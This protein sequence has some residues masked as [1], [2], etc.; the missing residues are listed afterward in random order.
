[1][2]ATNKKHK[3]DKHTLYHA[4]ALALLGA[5]SAYAADDAKP[6]DEN[7]ERVEVTGTRLKGVDMEG[8]SPVIDID[9]E[10][11]EKRGYD[12]VG[13]FL[14]DL[15]QTS[16]AGTFSEAGGIASGTRGQPA[17]SAGVS[18]R[19]LGSS[20]T[21]VLINGRRVAVDSFTNGFDSFVDVN[22]IPMSAIDRIEVLTDG[23]SSIYGSD[24]IAGVINFIL[25]K[26]YTGQE[27]SVMYGDDTAKD[28]FGRYN[29]TY[30]GGFAT[31][32][33]NTTVVLDYY[34]RNA[35]MNS[36]R[37]IDVTLYSSTRVTIDGVDHPEPWCG[38]D[39]SNG[40]TRCRYDY[41]S[42]RAI[43]S[44]T[45]NLGFTL[46]H[47]YDLGEGSEFF[48]EVMYQRNEGHAYEAPSS[49]S[50]WVPAGSA[51]IPQWALDI[52]ALDG[53]ADDIR[54]RSRFPDLRTQEFEDTTYRALAG[55]RGTIGNWDWESGLAIGKAESTIRHVAGFYNID[56][57]DAAADNGTFNP[58]NL[59]RDNSEATLAS[60]RETAPRTGESE[61]KTWD[62]RFNGD[63]FALPA[64]PVKAALGG[65]YRTEDMFDKPSALAQADGIYGLGATEAEAD[66]KQYAVYGEFLLPMTSSVDVITAFRYDHYSDFGS[67][68]NPK[69]SLRWKATEDLIFRA[70]WS[71]GFRAPS[72]S[73]LGSGTTLGSNFIDCGPSAAFGA[74]CG[75][76]GNPAGELEFDQETLGNTGL[77]AETSVA[78]NVGVSW[79]ITND[80][81]VT[82]DY[83]RYTH[84]DIVDVDANT[85]LRQCVDGSAPVVADPDDLNGGFG[86]AVD[87]NGDIFFLRT[88]FFNVGKQE[89]DGYDVNIKYKLDNYRFFFSASKTLSYER[90]IAP[91]QPN[92][93]LLGRLSGEN[94]I[95]RPELV[96]DFGVDWA[97][98]SWNWSLSG[99]YTDELGDGDFQYDDHPTVDAWLVWNASVGY[100]FSESSHV[101]FAVRNLTDEE[102]PFA[103]SPT[104]GY[105]ASVHDFFGRVASV[106][107]TQSF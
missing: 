50:T 103:S 102:P 88:G 20:S 105:A 1:M 92:E 97:S 21:L 56:A 47:T 72:L 48:A 90:Q 13:E 59:G 74:L 98:D 30:V 3:K 106:R 42:Q 60:L 81:Q 83:W 86:C 6:V 51:T 99:N 19:G 79:N 101:T 40:G 77:D 41:V 18:L 46:S 27:I 85:T 75:T 29:L 73:Q 33:S 8:A 82:L 66:R 12:S 107:Y 84:E 39:Q 23:A 28:D 34:D 37:P 58:F 14:K 11:L 62:F 93:D 17:G 78:R 95:G 76:V 65:E 43:Q 80:L 64:G 45:E 15:P 9:R 53:N 57:V 35:L 55:L 24:A 32:K 89:T 67:D 36:D 44:D 16:S 2:Q 94:E 25:R 5:G 91:D 100:D 7:A 38:D 31:E 71:T 63:L 4:I 10:E 54:V 49:F 70:S 96:A 52:D 68:V 26:D 87:A 69:V 22:S 104:S 61:V